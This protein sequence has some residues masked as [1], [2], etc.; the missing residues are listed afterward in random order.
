MKSIHPHFLTFTLAALLS[1][2]SASVLAQSV[3]ESAPGTAAP[4][5]GASSFKSYDSNG[6]GK[7]SLDEFKAQGGQDQAF[8]GIDANQD[9]S[10]SK[11]EFSKLGKPSTKP[12]SNSN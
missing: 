3:P 10:V 11:D 6:D 5:A 8:T 1:A 9:K 4:A 2:A 12:Y 7:I